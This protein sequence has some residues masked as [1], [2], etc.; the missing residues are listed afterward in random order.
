MVLSLCLGK[1]VARRR[2]QARKEA[3]GPD[4]SQEPLEHDVVGVLPVD[5]NTVL[6]NAVGGASLMTGALPTA[7][8]RIRLDRLS[9]SSSK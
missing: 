3:A 4:L 1:R 6:A 5:E 8:A 9:V 2:K 7:I